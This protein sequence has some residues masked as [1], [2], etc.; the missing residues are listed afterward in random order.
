MHSWNVTESDQFDLLRFWVCQFHLFPTDSGPFLPT[1]IHQAVPD[2]NHSNPYTMATNCFRKRGPSQCL[3]AIK[4]LHT[5][6][7]RQAK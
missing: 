2:L 7:G 5:M 6:P 3:S 1:Y 4:N